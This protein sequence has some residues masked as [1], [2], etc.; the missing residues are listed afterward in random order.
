[1]ICLHSSLRVTEHGV[2]VMASVAL[3]YELVVADLPSRVVRASEYGQ[4]LGRASSASAWAC[5][6]MFLSAVARSPFECLSGEIR[7]LVSGKE[8]ILS[9]SL[10]ST[11]VCSGFCSGGKRSLSALF[12]AGASL[13]VLWPSIPARNNEA[14]VPA[15]CLKTDS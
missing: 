1:M 5:T 12:S 11:A 4:H 14:S 9:L 3:R 7:I 2:S 15:V 6:S 8:A 10:A 13:I